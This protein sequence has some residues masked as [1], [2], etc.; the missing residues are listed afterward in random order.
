MEFPGNLIV[1]LVADEITE[2]QW[3][4]A[5]D[6]WFEHEKRLEEEVRRLQRP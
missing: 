6:V 1:R 5:V 3:W 4:Q 2:E